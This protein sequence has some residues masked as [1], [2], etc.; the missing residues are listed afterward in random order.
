MIPVPGSVY[1]VYCLRYFVFLREKWGFVDVDGTE[2]R[3]SLG[4]TPVSRFAYDS[5]ILRWQQS[6]R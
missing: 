1:T 2:Y 4:W 3:Y 5:V 6:W